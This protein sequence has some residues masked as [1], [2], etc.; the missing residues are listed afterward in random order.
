MTVAAGTRKTTAWAL[1]AYRYLLGSEAVTLAGSGVSAV[2]LPA[3]AVLELH[4][5]A[6]QVATLAFLSQLPS[7][8]ALWAGALSDRHAKRL[9]LLVSDLVAAGV[10]TTIPAAALA[11]ILTI[12]Q[13]YGLDLDLPAVIAVAQQATWAQAHAQHAAQPTVD[14]PDGAIIA[15]TTLE[16]WK[17]EP[18]RVLDLTP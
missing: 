11:G 3:L 10:L 15:T 9:Q 5:T 13:L 2:A 1:P 7:T 14:R 12:C 6:G 16:R 4:A 18:V 17:G 8:L